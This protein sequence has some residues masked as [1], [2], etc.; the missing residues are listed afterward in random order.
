MYP[1]EKQNPTGEAA[2]TVNSM[3]IDTEK[4]VHKSLEDVHD[5]QGAGDVDTVTARQEISREDTEKQT[6]TSSDVKTRKEYDMGKTKRWFMVILLCSAQF[7]DIFNSSAT[8]TALPQ[9]GKALDFKASEEQWTVAAYTLTFASFQLVGGRLSDLYHPKP[10]FIFGYVIVGVFSILCAVSVH[11]IMLIVFRAVQGI[12]AALTIPSCIS[13]IIQLVPDPKEQS[14]ALA[15]F[16]ASGAIGNAL[17]FVIGGVLTSRVGWKWVFYLVA[18]LVLPLCVLSWAV[19]PNVSVDDAK[20]KR[21][22]DM[23][24]VGTITAGLVLFV[25]AISDAN[26][27]GWGKPQIIVTLILSIVIAIAFFFVERKVPDPA[28]PPHTWSTPNIIP[29][30]IHCL[31]SYWFLYGAEIQ[32]VQVF[33]ELFGWSPLASSVY[34][35][36][37]GIAGLFSSSTTGKIA[38]YIPMRILLLLGQVFMCTGAILFA[39]ADR[40]EKYWSMIFPGMIVGMLGIGFAYV[41]G[42]IAIMSNARKG[43]EGVVGALMN[44]AFQLGAT[45]GLAILTSISQGV[46]N[47]LAPD[48]DA[49]TQFSGYADGFWSLV[50]LHGIVIIMIIVF[51]R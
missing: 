36:P 48:A 2:S 20:T 16:G 31:S 1:A 47:K 15:S 32:L 49:I 51:I 14:L 11:P 30:F 5:K 17:G 45:V 41:G 42:N 25:Y 43:E 12:G 21:Q 27:V 13:L 22:I 18:I 6:L 9:I 19:V 28:V 46:N 40:P 26:S 34:C 7:F 38:P 29:L 44:T 3:N 35:I 24:G 39:L 4:G 50:A 33:Q 10:V 8:L 23:L 37:I